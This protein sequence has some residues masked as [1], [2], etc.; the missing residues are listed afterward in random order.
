MALLSRST[1]SSVRSNGLPRSGLSELLDRPMRDTKTRHK[2]FVVLFAFFSLSQL[3]PAANASYIVES[4]SDLTFEAPVVSQ[5]GDMAYRAHSSFT[6]KTSVHRNGSTFAEPS[7]DVT[8]AGI[9]INNQGRVVYAANDGAASNG[10]CEGIVSGAE[11]SRPVQEFITAYSVGDT[12]LGS[13]RGNSVT[14][15]RGWTNQTGDALMFSDGPKVKI[16]GAG[17]NGDDYFGSYNSSDGQIYSAALAESSGNLVEVAYAFFALGETW[18]EIVSYQRQPFMVTV[19]GLEDATRGAFESLSGIVKFEGG[20]IYVGGQRDGISGIYSVGPAGGIAL[21]L[22]LPDEAQSSVMAN[23]TLAYYLADY[24][25]DDGNM[26]PAVYSTASQSEPVIVSGHLVGDYEFTFDDGALGGGTSSGV[27]LVGEV[28]PVGEIGARVSAI[29]FADGDTDFPPDPND[30]PADVVLW[31]SDQDGSFTDSGNWNPEEVPDSDQV[32]VFAPDALVQVDFGGSIALT[33]RLLVEDG[34]VIFVGGG[35]QFSS[36]SVA[37]PSFLLEP[38]FSNGTAAL[39]ISGGHQ[40]QTQN[41]TISNPYPNSGELVA[42]FL[43]DDEAIATPQSR[44]DNVGRLTVDA[45]L[46]VG[47]SAGIVSDSLRVASTPGIKGS[48]R[49]TPNSNTGFCPDISIADFGVVSVG[50]RGIGALE[51]GEGCAVEATGDRV[52][53]DLPGSDGTVTVDR[54]SWIRFYSLPAPATRLTVGKWGAGSIQVWDAGVGASDIIVGQH[55]GSNG[56]VIVDQPNDQNGSFLTAEGS[57]SVGV[58]GIGVLGVLYGTRATAAS[59]HIGVESGSLGTIRL[60]GSPTDGSNLDVS[61]TLAVGEGGTGRLWIDDGALGQ[62]HSGR[63][64]GGPQGKGTVRIDTGG[65]WDIEQDLTIGLASA[66][67][68]PMTCDGNEVS[69]G[70]GSLELDGD[71]QLAD[72]TGQTLTLD[73]PDSRISGTGRAS[74]PTVG[75]TNC[76]TLAPGSPAG[77]LTLDGNVRSAGG[78]LEVTISG[79]SNGEHDVLKVTG[80]ADLSGGIVRFIFDSF[81]LKQGDQITFFETDGTLNLNDNMRYEY[82]GAND[83]FEFEVTAGSDG[84]ITL[85]AKNDAIDMLMS[86]GFGD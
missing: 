63:I 56:S 33:E 19:K 71:G 46:E 64:G 23:P 54:G 79:L 4:S 72:V 8:F 27:A 65:A 69:L 7:G 29:V 49:I 30:P 76:G 85:T 50:Y 15:S 21:T 11:F 2:R 13:C 28:R 5:S 57:L 14:A 75:V 10:R 67:T 12:V 39:T 1:K 42:A 81:L 26:V 43:A 86:S 35:Y 80:N 55:P 77:M 73:G 44:W 17:Q 22:V 34:S 58:G 68:D 9:S 41:A 61:G 37:A 59:V 20:T 6:G 53:G 45:E 48:V 82:Q 24:E 36:G 31:N 84:S 25:D 60:M 78:V 38:R 74:F 51:I 70:M 47:W 16:L 3:A 40:F 62:S 18:L 32:A 66:G 83:G 52:I